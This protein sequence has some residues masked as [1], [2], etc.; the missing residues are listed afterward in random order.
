MNTNNDN[1]DLLIYVPK[2]VATEAYY[3]ECKQ[4]TIGALV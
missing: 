4:R 1:L 3:Y 2:D